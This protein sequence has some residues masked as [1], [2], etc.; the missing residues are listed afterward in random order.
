MGH[1]KHNVRD[2]EFN[3]FEVL[4]VQEK[5]GQGAFEEADED[6]ARGVLSELATLATGPL[7][8]PFADADRN[9]PVFDPKTHAVTV[10]GQQHA[11][12]R[13]GDLI[14]LQLA[15]FSTVIETNQLIVAERTMVWPRDGRYGSSTEPTRARREADLENAPRPTG[16]PRRADAYRTPPPGTAPAA[17]W[18]PMRHFARSVQRIRPVRTST[19]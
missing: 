12:V 11:T 2:L 14:G 5:L 8:E 4:K 6:T 18:A 13:P 7:A 10:P 3:L 1:Y 9:P 16:R 19:K 15:D 17:P